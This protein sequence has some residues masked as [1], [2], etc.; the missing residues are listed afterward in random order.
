M[1]AKKKI[2]ELVEVPEDFEKSFGADEM[3]DEDRKD[4]EEVVKKAKA[5]KTTAKASGAS[6]TAKAAAKTEK[7]TRIICRFP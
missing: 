5:T 2:E 4:M 6:K 3:T 1:P 7:K